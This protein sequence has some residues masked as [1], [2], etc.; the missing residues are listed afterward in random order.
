MAYMDVERATLESCPPR[1]A[2]KPTPGADHLLH[3]YQALAETLGYNLMPWQELVLRV[4][5][6][7][8]PATGLPRYQNLTV[9]VPRQAGKS[10]LGVLLVMHRML[11]HH[12]LPQ[13]VVYAAQSLDA[14]REF[15]VGDPE[16]RLRASGLYDAFRLKMYRSIA[17]TRLEARANGSKLRILPGRAAS[18]G[19]GST[20]GMAIIDE[21]WVLDSSDLEGAL[22]P[23]MRTISD[24][25]FAVMSTAGTPKSSYL[26]NKVELGR[27]SVMADKRQGLAY[28]E[29][30]CVD[31]SPDEED[32]WRAAVPSLGWTVSLRSLRAERE[33]LTEP[34]AKRTMLNQW[35][36]ASVDNAIPWSVWQE[37]L[38]SRA[39]VVDPVVFGV[40]APPERHRAVIVAADG[41]G[42]IEVVEWK[43]GT[44]W[45]AEWLRAAHVKQ[46]RGL[47][48]IV[49]HRSGPIGGLIPEMESLGLP[50]VVI[51]EP[52]FAQACGRLSEAAMSGGLRVRPSRLWQP[53][54]GGSTR[55]MRSGSWRIARFD[56]SSDVSVLCAAAMAHS[57]AMLREFTE[58]KER[59]SKVWNLADFM[60]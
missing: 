17:D 49:V 42:A 11:M 7:I 60:D 50:L 10:T 5:S 31:K 43:N 2:T 46:G 58:E 47:A 1:Y 56:A 30:S 19:H 32:A 44:W 26:R 39:R 24:P 16:A 45:V 27:A 21:A 23:T 37:C 18:A 28:F 9:T 6:E 15:W 13:R 36:D 59:V 53:A 29:W 48:A 25:L 12:Q 38:A 55:A 8:E 41:N 20:A 14:G 40:D 3:Q 4:A 51:N 52:D 34:D 57:H 54:I 22:I 33:A 35:V